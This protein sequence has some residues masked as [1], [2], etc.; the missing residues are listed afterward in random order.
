MKEHAV[1]MQRCLELAA[2]AAA[3]GESPVGS[4]IVK[5]GRVLGEAFEKSR[6]LKDIT[7][8]AEVLAIMNA[9]EEH[10]SCE[11]AVLYTNAE[12]CILCSYVIRHHKIAAVVFSQYSGELGGAGS[13]YPIL[14]AED[15]NA[16]SKPPQVIV[17]NENS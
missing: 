7:R 5:E 1:Y 10:G 14:T 3:E 11:G 9:V 16:W 6:Q 8:H 2:M 15:I 13:R 4:V 12:P 17:Y